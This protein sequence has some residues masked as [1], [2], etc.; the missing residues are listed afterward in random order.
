MGSRRHL[1]GSPLGRKGYSK[2]FLVHGW[3]R[4][5]RLIQ[6]NAH[7][8]NR[9]NRRGVPCRGGGVYHAGGMGASILINENLDETDYLFLVM[10]SKKRVIGRGSY[11]F[12]RIP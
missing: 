11:K 3:M 8:R 10:K 12:R 1:I 7:T 5:N 9:L 6:K 4:R 2:R